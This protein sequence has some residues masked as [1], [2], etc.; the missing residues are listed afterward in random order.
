MYSG[1]HI[2]ILMA[3]LKLM[4]E[5]QKNTFMQAFPQHKEMSI[6]NCIIGLKY[7]D[8]PCGK[9]KFD[10]G[11][12]KMKKTLCSLL[13]LIDD[14][15]IIPNL[16]S[17]S[18][19]SHNGFF[20]TWHS[21]TYDPSKTVRETADNVI[22]HIMA[23]CKLA[24]FDETLDVPGPN[25]FWIGFALHI[26]M[27]SY[28]P[29]HILRM[30]TFPMDYHKI[31]STDALPQP[32]LSRKDSLEL[33]IVDR[34]KEKIH[35]TTLKIT[36]DEDIDTA[37]EAISKDI[38]RKS[39]RRDVKELARFFLFHNKELQSIQKIHS[40]VAR[41]LSDKVGKDPFRDPVYRQR[42]RSLRKS[43]IINFFYYPAQSAMFHRKNDLIY[44]VK[45]YNMYDSCVLDTY[46]ILQIYKEALELISNTEHPMDKMTI[47]FAF[48]RKIYKYLSL[49][50]FYIHPKCND[51]KTGIDFEKLSRKR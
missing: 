1:G 49:V 16:Y 32:T 37:I 6:K 15:V 30:N 45:K 35:D 3:A 26:I 11:R 19:S 42:R 34:L 44:A 23:A 12:I 21:M 43:P 48:L 29:A 39:D 40:V 27:D 10:N 13:K 47:T 24:L 31:M 18:Y 4:N 17:L 51:L 5:T 8:Y 22:D 36:K 2:E 50:T 20:S 9:Y 28:S 14:I 25:S 46:M 33:K 38:K 41:T 7:P